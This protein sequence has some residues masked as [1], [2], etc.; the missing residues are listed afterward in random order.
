MN[1]LDVCDWGNM[2]MKNY[3]A[4][5]GS[6]RLINLFIT[7]YKNCTRITTRIRVWKHFSFLIQFMRMLV[8][9]MCRK[10]LSCEVK[11]QY[12]K[13]K[14]CTSYHNQIPAKTQLAPYDKSG[15]SF[16]CED[17]VNGKVLDQGIKFKYFT[18]MFLQCS[19][20]YCKQSIS[21]LSIGH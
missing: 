9:L 17:L 2:W 14:F 19:Q 11:S 21:L 1:C 12:L 5:I 8:K 4:N 6:Y 10:Q 7:L 15:Y 13:N 3:V 18:K 20:F 16:A